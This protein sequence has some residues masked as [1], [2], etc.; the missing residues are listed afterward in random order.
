MI[1][2]KSLDAF[3]LEPAQQIVEW[4][5]ELYWKE[6]IEGEVPSVAKERKEADEVRSKASRVLLSLLEAE[7]QQG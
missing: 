1:A 5:F 4:R 2:F 7:S 3:V 6:G